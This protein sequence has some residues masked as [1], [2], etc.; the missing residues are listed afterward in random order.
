M[1]TEVKICGLKTAEAVDR[2]VALGASHVGFH[3]L[4]EKPAQH[5]T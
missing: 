3:L 4:P 2:A 5:R 1:K